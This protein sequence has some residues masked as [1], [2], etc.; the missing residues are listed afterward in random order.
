M[1]RRL[2]FAALLASA[3]TA[4]QLGGDTTRFTAADSCVPATP[5]PGA[6]T[7]DA[8]CCSYG[9]VSGVCARNPNPGGVC[10]TT[11]DCGSLTDPLTGLPHTMICKGGA[12]TP[13]QT[14]ILRDN[15]DLCD[16]YGGDAECLA[17]NCAGDVYS[18]Y[19]VCQPN[20]APVVDLPAEL[21]V[22]YRKSAVLTPVTV[23]DPDG[24]V[25]LVYG[26]TLE[27]PLPA[28][29]PPIASLLSSQTIQAPT[30]T[31]SV[32]GDYVLKLTVTD[33]APPRPNRLSAS[34]TMMV[35]VRNLEP[36]VTA[37]A[38]QPHASRHVLQTPSASVS[39]ADGDALTC[40]W[41]ARSPSGAQVDGTPAACAGAIAWSGSFG[42]GFTPEQE[43]TW[44]VT[45]DVSDGTNTTRAT[46][47]YECVN[48]AP[49]ANAGATRY[50]NAGATGTVSPVPV[51]GTASDVN[52]DALTYAWTVD[53][54]PTGSALQGTAVGDALAI[55]LP[56]DAVGTYTLRLRATDPGGLFAESTTTVE[57]GRYV[58]DLA[59]AVN[60]ADHA[61]T[62]NKLVMV[63]P[64]PDTSA[65]QAGMIWVLDL[66]SGIETPF[67]LDAAP[68]RVVA[69][70]D[71][72]FAL[73]SD[74]VWV[75]RVN[76]G[77]T[78]AVAWSASYVARDL[79]LVGGSSGR[80]GY[81]FP[82]S[83][84]SYFQRVNLG[85]GTLAN[86]QYGTAGAGGFD[87]NNSGADLL[88]V[89]DGSTIRRYG[90]TNS[91]GN[92]WSLG[93]SSYSSSSLGCSPARLWTTQ[94]G[95]HVID[96]CGDVFGIT[97]GAR[98]TTSQVPSSLHHVDSNA[99]GQVVTATGGATVERFNSS[100][101][102]IG[103]D[104]VPRWA[105]TTTGEGA[106]PATDFAFISSD[107]AKRWAIVRAS[108]G[109]TAK[110]GLV[111]FP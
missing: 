57:V 93:S 3:L 45:L 108:P 19:G 52:G 29:A 25:P 43:G 8:D 105:S 58:R 18:A 40:T 98:V 21:V 22:S 59:H 77:T 107:G 54:A 104:A 97:L 73:V 55:Q 94:N 15:G 87:P 20:H 46:A 70:P 106:I 16:T 61:R 72:T 66:V 28:G 88:F 33:G 14:G 17:G 11:G 13:Y 67:A 1:T 53:A 32:I 111:T 65:A 91:G 2:A 10:R 42:P 90:V 101:V 109:G 68:T 24:D 47:T 5:G 50:G 76:L 63:G 12:C 41:H 62:A 79:A 60:D 34:D 39:D 35:R 99:S 75:R 49:L 80:D 6:C 4:C 69:A 51:T 38:N 56:A 103:S 78:P 92:N 48:D 23:S 74:G 83:A 95:Y 81:A 7:K 85:S 37:L 82:S 64:N 36:V 86:A 31:S 44:T 84:Y 30:F 89:L 96:S 9:C 110:T 100:F 27:P 71:A 26:W 102:S